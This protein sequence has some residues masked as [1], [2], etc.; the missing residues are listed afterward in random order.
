M[1]IQCGHM[2]RELGEFDEAAIHYQRAKEL[3]PADP[4]LAFHLGLLYRLRG[5]H[6][7]AEMAFEEALR[8]KPGSIEPALQLEDL[9]SK[10]IAPTQ[11]RLD[12]VEEALRNQAELTSAAGAQQAMLEELRTTCNRLVTMHERAAATNEEP[13]RRLEAP[14]PTI[15][16]KQKTHARADCNWLQS[17]A[18]SVTSQGG[19]DGIFQKI[20]EI[21]QPTSRFAV[22]FGG[23]DGKQMSN[24]HRL[25]TEESW[26]GVFVEPDPQLFAQIKI[27]NP[28]D[29]V[30]ALNQFITWDGDDTFDKI[31]SRIGA[32]RDIDLVC[33][34]IDGNDWHVWNA[35]E[36][37]RSKVVNV[38]FNPTVSNDVYFV[39]CADP[40]VNHGSSLLAFIELAQEKGYSLVCVEGVDAVFVR[41]EYFGLFNIPD[42]SI[43]AMFDPVQT[44]L[45]QGYDGTI[46]N[47]GFQSLAWKNFSFTYDQIQ[48]L[49]KEQRFWGQPSNQSRQMA[50]PASTSPPN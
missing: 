38:E 30:I 43:D 10:E 46:F 25:I 4:E 32:P 5:L 31:M 37:Y 13:E 50:C 35:I 33:I 6:R 48:L 41:N 28:Y 16:Y 26:N 14:M 47:C 20:F 17:H 49:P 42:N 18:R 22:E 36:T 7:A 23:Y 3:R 45:F 12:A 27:N 11:Q 34:D 44:L 1:H 15:I 21:I 40:A 24:I 2:H 19:Q 8:L 39:Q 9:F 29:R